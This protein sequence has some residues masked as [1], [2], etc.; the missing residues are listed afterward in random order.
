M[1]KRLVLWL[2][3]SA[4]TMGC[5]VGASQPRAA[6]YSYEVVEA[7]PHDPEAFTQGLVWHDGRLYESTGLYGRSSLREVDLEKGEILRMVELDADFFGEGLAILGD[8]IYQL[9]WREKK[10]F[11]YHL[12]SLE[13]IGEFTYDTEGWGIT[14]DGRQLIMSDGSHILYFLDPD[15]LQVVRKLEV[16]DGGVRVS[17]LNELEYVNGEIYANVWL[18]DY[19]A[20]IDPDTGRVKGWVDFSGLLDGELAEEYQVDV[21][22]GIAYDAENERLFVTGKLWPALYEV[23]VKTVSTDRN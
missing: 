1:R 2:I 6:L 8:K 15:T 11:I 4:L 7:Y 16:R 21:L 18:S 17:R 3:L 12:D 13:L 5:Q 22:N 19:V 23:R 10:G 20:A 14:T 9:T